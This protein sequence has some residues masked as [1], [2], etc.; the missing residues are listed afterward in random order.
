MLRKGERRTENEI[1]AAGA[2]LKNRGFGMKNPCRSDRGIT[3]LEMMVTVVIIGIVASMAVPRF[4]TAIERIQ[5]RSANRD[6]VSSLRLARSSAITDKDQY[7]VYFDGTAQVVYLFKDVVNPTSFSF[8]TGDSIVTADTL[9]PEFTYL[10]TDV[11]GDVILF[12]PNGG[13]RFTGGG[14]VVCMASTESTVAIA[15]HNILAA[16]GRVQSYTHYY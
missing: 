14:N 16:T 10:G 3:I 4:E 9:P 15:S 13:A 2:A 7:G 6:L 5:F 1:G 8:D 11:V 12:G